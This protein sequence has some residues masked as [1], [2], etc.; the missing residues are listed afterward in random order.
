MDRETRSYLFYFAAIALTMV[1]GY[2]AEKRNNKKYVFLIALMLSLLSGLRKNTVGIDTM[3]YYWM[4]DGMESIGDAFDYNDPYFYVVAFIIKRINGDPYLPITVF[5]FITNFLVV[6]RLWDFKDI[7]VFRYSVLRYITIFFFFSFNCM[8]QFLAVAIVFWAT[9]FIDKKNY[10][11]FLILVAIASTMHIASIIS[12]VFVIFDCFNWKELN[13]NQ[14]FLVATAIMC[15]PLVY[16]VS[17]RLAGER[18]QTYFNETISNPWLSFVV[19]VSLILFVVIFVI[20]N[21]KFYPKI[22]TYLKNSKKEIISPI[23]FYV[24][25]LLFVMLGNYYQFTERIGYYFYI[26]GTVYVGMAANGKK[27]KYLAR[28]IVLFIVIRAFL[29]NCSGNS[30]GQMPYLFNWE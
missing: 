30:M 11:M 1:F 12:Y 16:F 15:L 25:G 8:R 22:T 13:R 20:N 4:F 27:Y 19:K 7:S 3:N 29:I 9:R 17:Q 14:R 28:F 10:V 24:F 21:G 23:V 26:Y 6:Y 5:S 18:V 2:L